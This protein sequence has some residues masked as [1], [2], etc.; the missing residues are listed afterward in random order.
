MF[1]LCVTVYQGWNCTL[2]FLSKP[3]M[4]EQDFVS[5]SSLPPIQ[6]SICKKFTI[7]EPK[8]VEMIDAPY[9]YAPA[10]DDGDYGHHVDL[11]I[12]E[13][14][15]LQ[16]AGTIYTFSN[17]AEE[18]WQDMA[19]RYELFRLSDFISEL[20][21]WNETVFDW[22][23]IYEKNGPRNDPSPFDMIFYPYEGNST[24][25]CYTLREGMATFG[26]RFRILQGVAG[27]LV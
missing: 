6:M 26:T 3:L 17:S 14:S 9:E 5:I 13:N 21:F 19:S 15:F 22:N 11:P 23:I 8:V 20:G 1:G 4:V 25:L 12:F 16:P 7:G 24:L 2:H 27:N 10:Y 18:F